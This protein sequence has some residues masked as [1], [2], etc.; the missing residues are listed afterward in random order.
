MEHPHV[1]HE[2]I[3][4]GSIFHRYVTGVYAAKRYKSPILL[5]QVRRVHHECP[6]RMCGHGWRNSKANVVFWQGYETPKKMRLTSFKDMTSRHFL[7]FLCDVS[8]TSC[9]LA[10]ALSKP[11]T[12]DSLLFKEHQKDV[13]LSYKLLGSCKLVEIVNEHLIIFLSPG[14]TARRR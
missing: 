6:S 1:Q 3:F 9:K 2:N 11:S 5:L 14:T 7:E 12:I 13:H 10:I 4:Q 8:K